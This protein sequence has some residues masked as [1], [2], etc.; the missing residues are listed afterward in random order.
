MNFSKITLLLALLLSLLVVTSCGNDDDPGKDPDPT[1]VEEDKVNIQA[2]LDDAITCIQAIE[3]GGLAAA[4]QTMYGISEGEATDQDWVDD[5]FEELDEK[6]GFEDINDD[7]RLIFS[8]YTGTYT[9]LANTQEWAFAGTPSDKIVINLPASSSAANNT[10]VATLDSY[11]DTPLTIDGEQV[12]FPSG[13]V[14]SITKDGSTVFSINAANVQYETADDI[15][16]PIN[17]DLNIVTAPLSHSFKV[18][19]SD[20]TNFSVEVEMESSESCT[21]NFNFDIVL[22]SSDYANLENEDVERISGSISS[23]ML[24]L[25]FTLNFGVLAPLSTP[26]AAQWNEN[27]EVDVEYMGV[28]IG[29]LVFKESA[30]NED[31]DVYIRYKDGTEEDAVEK[32]GDGF[33]DKLESALFDLL[34]EWE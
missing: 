10:I 15:F 25:P 12:W 13:L 9:W 30:V 18:R 7:E 23:G 3:G 34:G 4:V 31:P 11:D 33:A 19:R 14:G 2:S 26:T 27:L 21:W 1:T 17:A 32:F 29:E 28:A 24:N 16:L 22:L 20:P 8:K 6:A 5:M